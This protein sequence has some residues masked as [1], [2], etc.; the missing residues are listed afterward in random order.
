MKIFRPFCPQLKENGFTKPFLWGRSWGHLGAR[1]ARG[2]TSQLVFSIGRTAQPP[3]DSLTASPTH[4]RMRKSGNLAGKPH[5]TQK[6]VKTLKLSELLPLISKRSVLWIKLKEDNR[7]VFFDA[8][9]ALPPRFAY[10]DRE[11]LSIVA[12]Y[13]QTNRFEKDSNEITENVFGVIGLTISG[14]HIDSDE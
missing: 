8:V 14:K 11:V 5:Y 10:L 3:V 6:E 7:H 2:A 12:D 1:G 9:V 4:D 13:E